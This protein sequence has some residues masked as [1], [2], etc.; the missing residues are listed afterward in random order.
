MTLNENWEIIREAFVNIQRQINILAGEEVDELLARIAK[1]IESSETSVGEIN[2][3]ITDVEQKLL[4]VGQATTTANE[5]AQNADTKASLADTATTNANDA[6]DGALQAIADTRIVLEDF[7]TRMTTALTNAEA[8]TTSA[9]NATTETLA[10]KVKAEEAL[11]E[12]GESKSLADQAVIDANDAVTKA[13]QASEK[14]NLAAEN[15]AGYD[16]PIVDFVIDDTYIK[17]QAVRDNGSTYR[18]KVETTG[19]PL[20]VSPNTETDFWTLE[21]KAG[22][23]GKG[24]VQSVNNELPDEDGNV[25]IIIPP[26]DWSEVPNK[27][28]EFTPT[29]HTQP[30][31]TIEELDATLQAINDSIS[32]IGQT[33]I[34]KLVSYPFVV[35]IIEDQVTYKIPLVS[36]D[37]SNDT[38]FVFKNTIVLYEQEHYTVNSQNEVVLKDA[39]L[40]GKM[41]FVILKNVP[42]GPTGSV[43]GSVIADGTLT[44]NKL[45]Q[46]IQDILDNSNRELSLIHI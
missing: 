26:T 16:L 23:D 8:A 13:N 5:S 37:K 36:F 1:A 31:E 7:T 19:N 35:D 18:A 42:I 22:R 33:G 40:T 30:I 43:G 3:L 25:T 34:P 41:L 21:A 32:L 24:T 44:K 45:E 15:I 14:A 10:A 9:N 38:L 46:S 29:A 12:A 27:P 11:V 6:R 39:P 4:E 17:H 28:T 20:P 2:Q